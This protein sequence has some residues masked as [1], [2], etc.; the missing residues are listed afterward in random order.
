MPETTKEPGTS[1]FEKAYAE[2]YLYHITPSIDIQLGQTVT[3][4]YENEEYYPIID[5]DQ[6][7]ARAVLSQHAKELM[8]YDLDKRH[9]VHV[10][11]D[12]EER[13]SAEFTLYNSN[14][15]GAFTVTT[16]P[17]SSK[18]LIMITPAP[19]SGDWEVIPSIDVE[20]GQK[21]AKEHPGEVLDIDQERAKEALEV[22]SADDSVYNHRL[23]VRAQAA[24]K[25]ASEFPP[26]ITIFL[27]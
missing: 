2:L 12:S 25:N 11:I 15:K 4:L 19:K 22:L 24:E 27:S 21:F 20:A 5:I 14:K 17:K 9:R 7:H 16:P 13:P 10:G 23:E 6:E 8:Q 26:I 1:F 3:K 18:D